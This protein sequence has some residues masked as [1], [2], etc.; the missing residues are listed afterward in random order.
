MILDQSKVTPPIPQHLSVGTHLKLSCSRPWPELK[1]RLLHL[2]SNSLTIRLF[3]AARCNYR[4]VIIRFSTL[5]PICA[6]LSN[7]RPTS[8]TPIPLTTLILI[9]STPILI[10][11][12][13][14]AVRVCINAG[15]SSLTVHICN[16]A[17]SSTKIVVFVP[18]SQLFCPCECIIPSQMI[19]VL[20]VLF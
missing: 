20:Q 7:K 16:A 19:A 14:S 3:K 6:P 10:L 5:L 9:L 4:L 13:Y 8:S 18:V 2:E 12:Y 17:G 11:N 1:P 15:P